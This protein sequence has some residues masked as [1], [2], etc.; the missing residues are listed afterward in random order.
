MAHYDNSANNRFNPDPSKE[1][2]W[3]PQTWDE[4]LAAWIDFAIPPGMDPKL[5]GR[6]KKVI[7]RQD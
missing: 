1:V 6:P 4:M 7:A 2:R 5:V 3:G